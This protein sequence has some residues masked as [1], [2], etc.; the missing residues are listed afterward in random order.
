M[1][2]WFRNINHIY[3]KHKNSNSA[4]LIE[5]PMYTMLIYKCL[6]YHNKVWKYCNKNKE[7]R[8]VKKFLSPICSTFILR[9]FSVI[10]GSICPELNNEIPYFIAR[11]KPKYIW[12][13]LNLYCSLMNKIFIFYLINLNY[14]YIY[15]QHNFFLRTITTTKL[16]QITN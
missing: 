13:I 5:R 9:Y 1:S 11:S 10:N 15:K 16:R 8:K 14:Y 4:L 12:C 7:K 6:F 3:G 2:V